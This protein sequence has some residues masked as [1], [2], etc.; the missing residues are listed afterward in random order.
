MI[1]VEKIIEDIP[2]EVMSLRRDVDELK[3]ELAMVRNNLK[4]G[5]A[6]ISPNVYTTVGMSCLTGA[7]T[8]GVCIVVGENNTDWRRNLWDL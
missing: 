6:N 8:S 7:E 3:A 2:A 4:I 1:H 5:F